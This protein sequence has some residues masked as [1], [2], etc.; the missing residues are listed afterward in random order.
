MALIPIKVRPGVNRDQTN[1]SNEG[2]WYE[3]DK[4]R[5]RS[6]FPQKIG[7]WVKYTTQTFLGTCRQIFNYVTSYADNFLAVGTNLKVYIE[8]G[9]NFYDITPLQATTTAGDVTFSASNGSSIVTVLDIANPAIAGNYVT[10]SGAASLGGN[11][12]SDILNANH[13][14]AST[15]NANAYTIVVSTVA[16]ASDVGNG[17]SSTIGYYDVDVGNAIL[18]YGYGWGTG[19]WGGA[20]GT[21]TGTFTVTI[22]SPGVLTFAIYTPVNNDTL[23]LSTTGALPTGLTAGVVYYVVGASTNTCRLSLTSSGAAINTTGT[24]SGTHSALLLSSTFAWGLGSQQPIYL[25]QR[26]WWFDNFDNDLIMNIRLAGVNQFGPIYIWERGTTDDPSSALATRAILLSSLAGATDVPDE[27]MQILVS[28]NDKHLLAFGCSPIGGGDSDPL[29]IRWADQDNPEKWTPT[30]TNSAGDIRISRGSYI[31][32]ALPTRQEI[33]VWTNASLYSLQYTG[34]TDVFALQELGDNV[35]I[36][37][38]RCCIAANNVVYWMGQDKFYVYSGRI[39]TLPCTLR[40]HVFQN[41]NYE[42]SDQ[43]ICGTNEGWNEI[44]WFYPTANSNWNDAYVVYNY[45]EKIWY[46]GTME[47]TAWLDN[48]IRQYP[49]A[50]TTA[51]NSITGYLYNHEDGVNDDTSPLVSYIQSSDFDLGDGEQFMLARRLLPDISFAGSTAATPEATFQMRPRN[52]PGSGF[53][54]VGTT[55]SKPVIESSVDIYTDQVF[56]RSRARQMAFK[57]TSENLGVQWQLGTPRLD[58]RQ[59]GKR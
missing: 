2:G 51:Q 30:A 3:C 23:I 7:G 14:I 5:F 55:D 29:L 8:Q 11:V 20:S 49:Q 9:G 45:L 18:T 46:Y 54:P 31:V 56:I 47:R 15:V 17:G 53:Q 4:I 36:I 43:I 59:D 42:Q 21:S 32:R 33:L 34:T 52:F 13:L 48:A 38:P 1:Y 57:I 41:L 28:Q 26:D 50:V 19:G 16:N 27:A 37:G 35:S 44:W 40:N 22:A 12:T 25:P 39:E 6:G 24:Q 10:F 58:I